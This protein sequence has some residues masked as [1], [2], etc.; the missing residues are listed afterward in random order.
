MSRAI[1]LGSTDQSTVIR[2]LNTDGTPNESVA[3][4]TSGLSLWYRR[5]GGSTTA[6][7]PSDLAAQNSAHSD[8][9]LKHLD[10]GYYRLDLPDAACASGATEV[11]T[12][13]TATGM[14]VVG[15]QHALVAFDPQDAVRLGLTALPNAAADA[16]GGLPISDAGGLDLDTLLG[17]LD[18]AITSR[19]APTT[20]GRTLDITAGGAAGV[21]WG[22][23]ENAG[24]TVG[25]SGTTVKTATDVETDTADIQS[26]IGEPGVGETLVSKINTLAGRIGAFS[27]LGENNSVAAYLRALLSK[28]APKPD[29]ITEN[30]WTADP[31]TDSLEAIRDDRTVGSSTYATANSQTSILNRL[32]TPA[33]ASVSADIAAVKAKTDNLP[34]SPAAVGSEMALADGAITAAKI[35]ADAI[36]AAKIATGAIDADALATDGVQEIRDAIFAKVLSELSTG[37]PSATPTL[38]QAIMLLFMAMRNVG[39][40]T[41]SEFRIAND[42]GTTICEADVSDDGSVFTRSK[43]RAPS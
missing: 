28:Q 1:K 7:T 18:A 34:A 33:G 37:Q 25:L 19:L 20:A 42:A 9:G 17:R 26:R 14:V 40:Q 4:A 41:S 22:N 43:L 27:L 21:D 3:A 30:G 29:E 16:A 13:G 2:I 39:V 35:A 5:N 10:D 36:T 24:S 11:V 38:E 15:S 32:G 6:I 23:V 12:G 31:A 8:G